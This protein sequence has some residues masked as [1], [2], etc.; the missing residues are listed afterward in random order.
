MITIEYLEEADH[1][2]TLRMATS[3][4]ADLLALREVFANLAS[5]VANN[6]EVLELPQARSEGIGSFRLIV[7]PDTLSPFRANH[8]SFD[9]GNPTWFVWTE[10]R[11]IWLDCAE[12]IDPLIEGDSPGHQYLA[13]GGPYEVTVRFQYKEPCW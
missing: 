10:A 12:L 4:H 13:D 1:R 9:A 3:D 11:E 8:V 7:G 5:G 2:S 6:V